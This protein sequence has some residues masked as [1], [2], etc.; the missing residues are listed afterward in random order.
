[1]NI[2]MKHDKIFMVNFI[3][4]NTQN[5]VNYFVSFKI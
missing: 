4:E 1:M 5:T 2:G 3:V